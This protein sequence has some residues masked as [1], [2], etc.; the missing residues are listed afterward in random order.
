[1]ARALSTDFMYSWPLGFQCSLFFPAIQVEV[2]RG[3]LEVPGQ[4]NATGFIAGRVRALLPSS[5]WLQKKSLESCEEVAWTANKGGIW[6]RAVSLL[7]HPK[8]L[9]PAKQR[10]LEWM[11]E[12]R[13]IQ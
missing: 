5:L 4:H 13:V 7:Q 1:M 10:R 3:S 8:K 6:E 11:K 9:N 2:V 12:L